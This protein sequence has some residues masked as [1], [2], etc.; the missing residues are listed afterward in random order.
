LR[1]KKRGKKHILI[2]FN[3]L[4]AVAELPYFMLGSGFQLAGADAITEDQNGIRQ[5]VV[6]PVVS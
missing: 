3:L 5:H 2:T 4:E 6:D 1:W